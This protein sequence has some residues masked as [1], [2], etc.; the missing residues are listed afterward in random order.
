M[1]LMFILENQR[2]CLCFIIYHI[3]NRSWIRNQTYSNCDNPKYIY[4]FPFLFSA[5][6]FEIGVNTNHRNY[7]LIYN[8]VHFKLWIQLGFPLCS[9][10]IRR[11][12]FHLN[13]KLYSSYPRV[14]T[15][16]KQISESSTLGKWSLIPTLFPLHWTLRSQQH[17]IWKIKM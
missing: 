7:T 4:Y 13:G 14:K 1:I 6:Y 15:K 17:F 8:F 10:D 11:K 2:T 5:A 3:F 9:S 16:C 12:R